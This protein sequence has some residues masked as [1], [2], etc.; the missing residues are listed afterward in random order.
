[1]LWWTLSGSGDYSIQNQNPF[2]WMPSLQWLP[3]ESEGYTPPPVKHRAK[4]WPCRPWPVDCEVPRCFSSHIHSSPWLENCSF[5]FLQTQP[6]IFWHRLDFA[7][8]AMQ[9]GQVI[10][11]RLFWRRFLNLNLSRKKSDRLTSEKLPDWFGCAW[12][13]RASHLGFFK[14]NLSI[15]T[16]LANS[17]QTHVKE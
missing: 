13:V 14:S 8:S 5:V 3:K 4:H 9:M 17:F 10:L 11:Q 12:I 7:I 2:P 15:S 1:M 6:K 16:S